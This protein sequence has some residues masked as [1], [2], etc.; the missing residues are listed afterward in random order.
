[1]GYEAK[2]EFKEEKK[3]AEMEYEAKAEFKEE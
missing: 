1:V 3:K 2:A